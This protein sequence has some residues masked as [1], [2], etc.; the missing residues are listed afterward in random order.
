MIINNCNVIIIAIIISNCSSAT[1]TQNYELLQLLQSAL[2]H[3]YCFNLVLAFTQQFWICSILS[4][5]PC[6]V[7]SPNH[8]VGKESACNP[9]AT[10]DMDLIPGAERSPGGENGNPLQYSCLENPMDRG[11]WRA[12]VQRLTK[13]LTQLSKHARMFER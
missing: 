3:K 1:R 2:D 6:K 7:G 11:S 13:S 9:G 10:G 12:T 4:H 8:S 5:T